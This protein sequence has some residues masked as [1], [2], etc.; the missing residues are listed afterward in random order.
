[1]R[2]LK[3][4]SFKS[5]LRNVFVSVIIIMCAILICY[6]LRIVDHTAAY[7][8]MIF[9][10]AVF[11]ISR[12][13]YGY[14]YGIISSLLSVLIVNFIF[15][16][17]YY[18]FNFTLSGYPVSI[19]SML[20]VAV[21]TSTLTSQIKA[22]EKIKIEAEREKMRSNLLRA[23]SHDLRT[24]LTSIVGASSAMIENDSYISKEQR[25]E[26]LQGIKE[27]SEWLI[28][29]VENLLSITRID[30]SENSS[31]KITKTP[32]AVEEVVAASVRKFKKRFP[33][34]PIKLTV[35]DE[36]LFIPMDA[37]LIEQVIINILEN[38]VMHSKTATQ[39]ILSVVAEDDSIMFKISDNGVGISKKKLADIFNDA[40][41][42]SESYS[43][44]K[45]NMGIG[46]SVCNTIIKAHNGT[47]NA[48]NNKD[49]GAFFSFNLPA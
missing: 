19:L 6:I 27:D 18:D 14:V 29:M 11:I 7:A 42:M 16:Y 13:T 30:N 4:D 46:L 44:A 34:M 9:I 3:R 31:A 33:D 40:C 20:V 22:Q 21:A 37:M 32:E 26:F 5:L 49:G 36:L 15:T 10:L 48:G 2:I 47:M 24:P 23:V 1:M 8:P 25:I 39:I 38:V 35:P 41:N 12:L 17:P 28:R 45:R 43:D